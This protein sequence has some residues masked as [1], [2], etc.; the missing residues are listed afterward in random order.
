MLAV[1]IVASGFLAQQEIE[2][3]RMQAAHAAWQGNRIASLMVEDS[4]WLNLAG[5]FWLEDGAWSMGSDGGNALVLREGNAPAV[6]GTFERNDETIHF[7]AAQGVDVTI[8][9]E[10]SDGKSV[11]LKHD[12]GGEEEATIL[13]YGQ[14]QWWLI[15]RDGMLGVRVRNLD[16]ELY[17][18]FKGIESFAFDADWKIEA[19]F[20]P[21]EAPRT[22]AYPTVLGTMREEEAPGVLVFTLEG[23]QYEMV[24]FERRKGSKLFLVFGDHTNGVDTYDGGRFL[25]VDLPDATGKTSIDF[26]RA[27]NPPCAFSEYSTC[28]QPLQ[29]NRL[30]IAV[31]AG[32]QRYK[33][34]AG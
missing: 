22:F 3:I 5:L 17:N 12:A 25:Y 4:S 18:N 32:E 30:S 1:F 23:R 6:L 24:P 7:T 31:D 27:Y 19:Q 9:G 10:T 15:A 20:L 16:S 33:Q 11:L 29:Q 13:S 34:P 2:R 28:P 8:D 21:F 14:L 26:N